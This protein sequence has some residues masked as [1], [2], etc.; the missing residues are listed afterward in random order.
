[1]SCEMQCIRQ[2]EAVVT[3]ELTYVCGALILTMFAFHILYRRCIKR[4]VQLNYESRSI[5]IRK[6]ATLSTAFRNHPL[7]SLTDQNVTFRKRED[8][9]GKGEGG[10]VQ[11]AY[12]TMY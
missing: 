2:N 7:P 4:L 8:R 3:Q 10:G 9:E 1:M 5:L 6:N 12:L 11:F